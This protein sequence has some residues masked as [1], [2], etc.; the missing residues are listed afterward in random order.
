MNKKNT[1]RLTESELKK[2]ITES[3]KNILKERIKSE[4]GMTDDE[5]RTRRNK[6]YRQDRDDIEYQSLHPHTDFGPSY[7]DMHDFDW[8][9]N[10][11]E[12]E[13]KTDTARI[14]KHKASQNHRYMNDDGEY[15]EI[16]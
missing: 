16:Y 14:W 9:A 1:I 12:M 4:K 5:V 15:E 11:D 10:P 2:V 13:R 7:D 3:V 6:N 8:F